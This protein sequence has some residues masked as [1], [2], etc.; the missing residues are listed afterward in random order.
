MRIFKK[1]SDSTADKIN[2]ETT[3][4]SGN[5]TSGRPGSGRFGVSLSSVRTFDSLKNSAYRFYF[6]GMLGQWGAMNMQQVTR[7]LLIYRLTGSAAILGLMS[8]ANGIP[9]LF[10]S[11]FG[12]VIADRL[13]KKHVLLAGLTG[14]AVVALSCCSCLGDRLP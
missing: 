11:L 4:R 13:R 6:F 12:G 3:K 5:G 7:S 2:K 8:L 14:E 9:M 10:F 1:H